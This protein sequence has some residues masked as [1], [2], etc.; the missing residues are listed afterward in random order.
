MPNG[1]T[2]HL[3]GT[4]PRRLDGI[5]H[6]PGVRLSRAAIL[7]EGG[8]TAPRAPGVAGCRRLR[9]GLGTIPAL[10]AGTGLGVVLLVSGC[11][12]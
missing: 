12:S 9:P 4:S 1:V 8:V 2:H 6:P 11:T 5:G 10:F 7:P 3:A